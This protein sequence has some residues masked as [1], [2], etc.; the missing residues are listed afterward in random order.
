[1]SY[2][3]DTMTEFSSLFFSTRSK[4]THPP[5]RSP[6]IH[7]YVIQK[8]FFSSQ[9]LFCGRISLYYNKCLVFYFDTCPLPLILKFCL[10]EFLQEVLNLQY[11]TKFIVH[12]QRELHT[13]LPQMIDKLTAVYT[14]TF[15]YTH[16]HQG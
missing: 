16:T 6:T 4:L 1:M 15:T 5:L 10:S 7:L 14:C 12:I 11:Q 13:M 8:H 3:E 9:I 2:P